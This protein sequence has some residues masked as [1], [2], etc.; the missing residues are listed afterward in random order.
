MISPITFG[1]LPAATS[2]SLSPTSVLFLLLSSAQSLLA[3]KCG[4]I[5]HQACLIMYAK[6][7][8]GLQT[9]FSFGMCKTCVLEWSVLSDL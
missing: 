1:D 6:I 3:A 4:H 9:F 8:Q 2:Q 5:L 7:H